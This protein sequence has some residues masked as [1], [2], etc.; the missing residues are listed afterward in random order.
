MTG[1]VSISDTDAPANSGTNTAQGGRAIIIRS[2]LIGGLIGAL[3]SVLA[4]DFERRMVFDTWQRVSP[5]EITADNVAVVLIDDASVQAAGEWPWP[6]YVTAQLIALIGQ[7]EPSAIGID[8]YFTEPDRLSP[9]AFAGRYLDTEMDA[10]TREKITALPDMDEYF[11]TILGQ[12]PSVLARV[13][14]SDGGK[15]PDEYFFD[16]VV[17]GPPPPGSLRAENVLASIFELDELAMGHGMVNGAPDDDGVVRRVP[18]S[19]LIQDIQASGLA[20]ELARIATGTPG[21]RWENGKMV[22]G[23]A[24]ITADQRGTMQFR[25]GEIPA[26]AQYSAL[27]VLGQGKPVPTDAF[28]GKVVLVGV[29]ATGTYDIVATPLKSELAGVLVQ[30][31]A[32]DAILEEQWLA[33]PPSM[34]AAEIAAALALLVLILAAGI[35]LRTW[36]LWPAF[37]LALALPVFSWLAFTRANLL[38]D[39]V[40]PL[41]V[42]ICA[43]TALT[44]IRY[45][46]AR[47][48]RKRLAAELVEERVRASVQ[49]GELDAARR[50]QM[51]MVPGQRALSR[52]DSRTEISAVLEPAKSVGGDFF[53]AVKI[54][55]DL[56]LFMVGDVTGKGVPAA[57]FMALS[58]TLSK[59]NLARAAD[60]LADPVAALNHDLMDEA[61][62]EMGLTMLV[63]TIDCSTGAVHMVNAGHENPI[64]VHTDGTLKTIEMVGGP[65]F[66]VT[67]FPYPVE[68][69]QLAKGET[70]VIITDGATEAA[71]E[72]GIL[73][74]LGGVEAALKTESDGTAQ[75]RAMHL[76]KE[77]RMFEGS[78]DP[79][80]DLTIFALRYLGN[81]I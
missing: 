11:G 62:P 45:A 48:E 52:L 68:Q 64:L 17:D 70:L 47:A 25:M 80:D 13:A 30:A 33:R 41:L 4:A 7:G 3:L 67:D 49:K 26:A 77:V 71:N 40:R 34:L 19:V 23:D 65:P 9:E 6:R 76:A 42:G 37:G 12:V 39:P 1:S 51:S 44:L 43:A 15:S 50:I 56:L 24:R 46:L 59:S 81:D 28:K 18:L 54:N 53:D 16:P 21:L 29:S 69:L 75:S 63:G 8:I 27:D 22:M 66:C 60:G 61:D 2:V 31:Q 78:N 14:T 10:E 72:A 74:G 73:F 58:K 32:V 5:R 57:L 38:F 35:T 36:L 20:M 79:T 55:K